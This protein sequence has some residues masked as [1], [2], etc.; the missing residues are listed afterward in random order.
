MKFFHKSEVIVVGGGIVGCAAA[1]YLTKGGARVTIIEREGLASQASGYSAGMLNPLTGIGIPGCLQEI[2]MT[3][4]QMHLNLWKDLVS[5]TGFDFNPSRRSSIDVIF[6][7]SDHSSLEQV[8]RTYRDT[9]GFKAQWLSD[10]EIKSVSS[11]ISAEA[12]GGLYTWGNGSLDSMLLTKALANSAVE[13]GSK[14]I[15]TNVVGVQDQ[16]GRINGLRTKE[17]IIGCD[18][19]IFALGPWSNK[20]EKWLGVHVPVSP[21][22]GQILR[23]HLSNV[24]KY[25]DY[26]LNH[27]GISLYRKSG[28][29]VWIGA[30]EEHQGYDVTQTVKA[31]NMLLSK[32]SIIVPSI[33]ESEIINQTVCLRPITPDWLPIIGKAP[34]WS[35]AWLATGAGKKGILL[36][37]AMGKSISDLITK[38]STEIP[39]HGFQPER[40]Q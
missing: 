31:K 26:D 2:A 15:E 25:P 17:G 6:D 8:Y 36:G 5:E 30:T 19:V 4:F 24:G 21:L 9:D 13:S 39:I 11:K 33:I 28:G 10:S 32:A 7:E 23:T 1:Y 27:G 14:L 3:S 35:N 20:I 22:K 38:K 16:Y 29:M 40:F 18:H 12:I 37:P 34:G